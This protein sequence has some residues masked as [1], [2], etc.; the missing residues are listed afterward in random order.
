MQQYVILGAGLDT[1]AYR[2]PPLDRPLRIW[3]VDHPATQAWKRQR[4]EEAAIAI[5]GN[6]TFAPID[7]EHESLADVL[8]AAGFEP[9]AGA[10]FS[11]LGVVPYLSRPAIMATL[12]YV[13]AATSAGGGIAFD[14]A[15]PPSQLTIMQRAAFEVLSARVRAAGEPWQ[16]FFDPGE[17]AGELRGLGYAVAE[18]VPPAT[19]NARYLAGRSDRLEVGGMGHLMWAGAAPAASAATS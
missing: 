14:F 10:V 4:L 3:E 15:I 5:P 7:F 6:L 17:L 19:I 18:D 2:Q 12:A 8:L 11:W 1:F 13:A 16:T 9:E